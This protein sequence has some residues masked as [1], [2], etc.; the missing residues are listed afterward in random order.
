MIRLGP[1]A[2]TVMRGKPSGWGRKQLEPQTAGAADNGLVNVGIARRWVFP[3]I[4]ILIF[5]ALQARS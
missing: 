4:R 1:V 2:S 3:I 5:V